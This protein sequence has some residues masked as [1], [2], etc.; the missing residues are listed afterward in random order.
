MTLDSMVNFLAEKRGEGVH[1]YSSRNP[2]HHLGQGGAQTATRDACSRRVR[3]RIVALLMLAA[4]VP[5]KKIVQGCRS[6]GQPWSTG[7][8]VGWSGGISDWRMRHGRVGL[9]KPMRYMS[10]T[11]FESCCETARLRI[12]VH[13]LDGSSLGRIHGR[14]DRRLLTPSG[15]RNCCGCMVSFG[16]RPSEHPESPESHAARNAH[17]R[18]PAAKKGLWSRRPITNSGSRTGSDSNSSRS[19][20]TR[21]GDGASR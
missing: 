7:S 3:D 9:P 12:R 1:A 4:Q 11:W 13:P 21:T 8:I 19:R 18:P 6:R 15:S 5:L 16:A 20:R 10:A 17:R 2:F 14:A